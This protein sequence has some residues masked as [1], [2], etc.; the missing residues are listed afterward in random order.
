M[1]TITIRMTMS[2]T[3]ATTNKPLYHDSNNNSTLGMSVK[4]T[5]TKRRQNMSS[6]PQ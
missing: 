1:T 5:D 2:T 3:I 4:I 6:I